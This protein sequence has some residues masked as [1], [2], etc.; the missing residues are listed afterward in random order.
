MSKP[1]Q[2]EPFV[3]LEPNIHQLRTRVIAYHNTYDKDVNPPKNYPNPLEP[4][5][6]YY[7]T[8]SF[9]IYVQ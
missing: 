4:V 7:I 9:F 6:H 2:S 3:P 5:L 8:N 1:I